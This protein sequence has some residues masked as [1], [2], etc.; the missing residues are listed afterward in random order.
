MVRV[1]ATF[2]LRAVRNEKHRIF[3]NEGAAARWLD[4]HIREEAP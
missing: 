2:V 3:Q 4:Q 1:T